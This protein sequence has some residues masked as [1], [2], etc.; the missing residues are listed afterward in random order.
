V[1]RLHLVGFTSE[2]DGLIFS[3]KDGARSGGYVVALDSELLDAIRDVLERRD[4]HRAPAPTTPSFPSPRPA[5]G[6]ALSP[7]EIQARLRAG[8][9]IE[10]VALE[11]GVDDDWV[12]R[13]ATPVFAE[14]A[15]VAGRAQAAVLE[16]EGLGLSSES[17]GRAVAANVADHGEPLTPGELSDGWDAYQLRE[18]AW[19]VEFRAPLRPAEDTARWGFDTRGARLTALNPRAAELGWVGPDGRGAAVLAPADHR[20][21]APADH[22]LDS[23][24][25][26]NGAH[27]ALPAAPA[28]QLP[29]EVGPRPARRVRAA[30]KAGDAPAPAARRSGSG[31]RRA[32]GRNGPGGRAAGED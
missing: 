31:V 10:D 17:L 16:L 15:H 4:R 14:R 8:R 2:L 1:Q 11:A 6:S 28:E 30:A 27:P 13:F 21:D 9:R 29:L 20:L 26:G 23:P 3:A 18:T 7:R 22:P 32:R 5:Q 19:V 12:R 25:E 24:A